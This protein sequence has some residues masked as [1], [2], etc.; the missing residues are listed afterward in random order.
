VKLPVLDVA[1]H[2]AGIENDLNEALAAIR[3]A[4]AEQ[5][6]KV[7]ALDRAALK[8]EVVREREKA[9]RAE[10]EAAI[11]PA[12]GKLGELRNVLQRARPHFTTEGM[13]ARALVEMPD[14]AAVALFAKLGR[15]GPLELVNLASTP[16][17]PLGVLVAIESEATRRADL[18]EDTRRQVTE[19]CRRAPLPAD[20]AREG[21]AVRRLLG[22]VELAISEATNAADPVARL[23]AGLA[24]GRPAAGGG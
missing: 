4:R 12:L 17:L 1:G 18:P 7:A 21:E 13:R 5:E 24:H 9:A 14:E 8:P 19:A 10:A 22:A 23:A 11:A 3:R 15:L 16:D 6:R 2:A 20:R